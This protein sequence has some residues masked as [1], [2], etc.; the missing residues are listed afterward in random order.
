MRALLLSAL[1]SAA[2][3]SFVSGAD[4][5]LPL[6][7][8]S[9]AVTFSAD[10]RT[11]IVVTADK[12]VRQWD[13]AN[14]RFGRSLESDSD[15]RPV[16]LAAAGHIGTTSSTGFVK[17]REATSGRVTAD[18]SLPLARSRG[19]NLVSS[20]DGALLA[21]SGDDPA[22]SSANLIQVVD[23]MGRLQFQ[24]S[25]GLGSIGA[26]AFSPDGGTLVAASFD[27][28]IRVWDVRSGKLMH[29]IGQISVATF[30]AVFSP[31]GKYLATAGAD[32]IIYLWDTNSWKVARRIE[33]QP[34]TIRELRFS[35][36]GTKLV[37]GGM[38][39][40]RSASP[41]KVILWDVASGSRIQTWDAEHS[42]RG[43]AFSPDGRQVAGADG[44]KSVKLWTVPNP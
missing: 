26:M 19:G 42:V 20:N 7:A 17:I 5:V 34:E 13:I 39:E 43:L 1:A 16:V 30:D 2:F 21:I 22:S 4:Q 12:K 6:D 14:G 41:V 38:N 37:S 3:V 33:G 8:P 24:S 28:D 40:M 29:L 10:S 36:D 27:T 15:R 35:P 23:R 31:D 32:R 25:A 44:S 18:F 9:S 11:L